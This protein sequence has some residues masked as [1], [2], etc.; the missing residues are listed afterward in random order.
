[1]NVLRGMAKSRF[2][3]SLQRMARPSA[4]TRIRMSVRGFSSLLDD[5]EGMEYD[6]VVVGAGPA[7]LSAAIRLKQ[8]A[9]EEDKELNVCVVEKGGDVGAHI[10]SGNVFEP[11]ALAELFPDYLEREAPLETKVKED[12]LYYFTENDAIPLPTPPSLHNHGNYIISL[13]NLCVWLKEQAE[14]LGV[15]IYPGFA[16]NEVLYNEQGQVKGVA[17]QDM[18]IGKDGVEK[19]TFERGIELLGKQTLFAEGVRG[20]LSQKIM[21]R[22]KLREECDV[23]TYGLGLKEV[24]E[25]PEENFEEGL[26]QHSIGWP[27]K[28]WKT[29][30]GTFLYHMK[31][32]KVLIGMVVGLDYENPYINPYQEFQQFKHHPYV[33]KFLEGGKCVSYGARAINEGGIQAIPKLTFPG[34]A[35]IGC[36]AGFLN[37]PKIK[38]S[39]TAMK[40]GMVAADAVYD[41]F[42]EDEEG[43]EGY[44]CTEYEAN[45]KNSWVYE[46]LHQVRNIHPSMKFGGLPFFAAWSGLDSFVLKG[47]VPWTWRNGTEDWAKT[48]P[49]KFF[50]P[51][52]YPKPDGVLSFDLLT[53][54][55]RSG[56]YH[57]DDQPAHLKIRPHLKEVPEKESYDTYAGPETRFCPAKVYEYVAKEENEPPK[58]VINAQNCLHCKT[59]DIKAPR[60]YI[61]WTVPE[62]GGGPAYD[63]M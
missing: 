11:R 31:D 20:S 3:C 16:A 14:E 18:G 19:D 23:Q 54:L 38:G 53:N 1:M 56:T 2:S 43:L 39:H 49:A 29:W 22:F 63:G 48:K 27:V 4:Y 30:Q 52:D 28:D 44:E 34:G 58:L 55:Q 33:S 15:E 32:N 41:R 57:E 6:V 60:N 10:L 21:K 50:K 51:I 25:I 13:G 24:W 7:G 42:S 45:L 61:D 9:E 5:R 47:R 59:C 12:R 62:G 46:E 40:S 17:T 37:V 8:R 35:L 36:S 26:V